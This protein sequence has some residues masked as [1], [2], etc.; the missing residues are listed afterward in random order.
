MSPALDALAVG[1]EV[2]R[3]SVPFERADLVR[4]A[5]ASGDFNSSTGTAGSPRRSAC[6]T[7]SRTG[8]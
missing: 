2:L 8:C 6:P 1:D 4:Y 7:S 5:G 3:T